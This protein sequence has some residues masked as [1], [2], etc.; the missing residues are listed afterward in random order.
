MAPTAQKLGFRVDPAEPNYDPSLLPNNHS[1]ALGDYL[2][3]VHYLARE[4]FEKMPS[5]L[6]GKQMP[7]FP[8]K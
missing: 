7:P 6:S 8:S 3:Q 2:P 4:A 1:G 5:P